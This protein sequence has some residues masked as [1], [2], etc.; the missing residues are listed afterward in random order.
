MQLS[1]PLPIPT[2]LSAEDGT[3]VQ[4]EEA[5][6]FETAMRQSGANPAQIAEWQ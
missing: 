6:D 5:I 4:P 3:A 2:Q 1:K